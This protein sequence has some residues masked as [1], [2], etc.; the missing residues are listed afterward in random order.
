MG[1]GRSAYNITGALWLRGALNREALDRAFQTII[2]R[3]ESLR[4]HFI[5]VDG[6]PVQVIAPSL[7]IETPVEDISELE[8]AARQARER[9][10]AGR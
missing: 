10:V 7:R 6:E 3:H 8:E 5:E 9:R 1:E 2:D 4:T